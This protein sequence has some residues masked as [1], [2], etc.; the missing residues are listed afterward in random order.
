MSKK[1]QMSLITRR[2]TAVTAFKKSRE[3]LN[4][5][6]ETEN[7]FNAARR[8]REARELNDALYCLNV[9]V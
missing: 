7:L 6:F 2:V 9:F 8:D 3:T 4:L 1:A 5:A